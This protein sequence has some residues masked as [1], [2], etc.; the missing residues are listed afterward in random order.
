MK[1][2]KKTSLP[3]TT[4]TS[5][6]KSITNRAF[7]INAPLDLDKLKGAKFYRTKEE[8]IASYSYEPTVFTVNKVSGGYSQT[9]SSSDSIYPIT[10]DSGESIEDAIQEESNPLAKKLHEKLTY[11]VSKNSYLFEINFGHEIDKSKMEGCNFFESE[12]EALELAMT[13][14]GVEEEVFTNIA[15]IF[16]GS[17]YVNDVCNGCN[18]VDLVEQ[19]LESYISDFEF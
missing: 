15:R 6:L 16:R 12:K 19:T 11:I 14:Q 5:F 8:L 18:E 13:K 9:P 2:T 4:G 7:V 17:L 10:L 1:T 3:M